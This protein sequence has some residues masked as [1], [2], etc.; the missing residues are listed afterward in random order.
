MHAEF[1]LNKNN[2]FIPIGV[3]KMYLVD[4][5]TLT[6]E[7]DMSNIMWDI[8]RMCNVESDGKRY[9]GRLK[10]LDMSGAKVNKIV[11]GSHSIKELFHDCT[12]LKKLIL[13]DDFEIEGRWF[14]GC[15]GLEEILNG[16]LYPEKFFT[17]DNGCVYSKNK[18]MALI[19]YPAG[20]PEPSVELYVACHEIQDCAFEN[21]EN[22]RE[23]IIPSGIVANA[24]MD[25]F[26][27]LDIRKITIKVPKELYDSYYLHN[28]WG[29]FRLE[30]IEK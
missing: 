3:G 10:V 9:G 30:T 2:L 13:S 19:K 26:K 7:M 5:L 8:K 11:F 16:T 25:A 17:H 18:T 24:K 23:L 15:I 14:S 21:C 29:N 4:S 12:T 6:G 20:R 1:E 27:G 28:V 22:L